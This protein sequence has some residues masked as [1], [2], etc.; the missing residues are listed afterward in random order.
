MTLLE[1]YNCNFEQ[2][3]DP[4]KR[5]RKYNSAP[6]VQAAATAESVS[7]CYTASEVQR[8][9]TARGRARISGV[10]RGQWSKTV[11]AVLNRSL[12]STRGSYGGQGQ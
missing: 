1:V 9:P 5:I 12:L 4:G 6:A 10:I 8:A 11:T 7:L 2:Y 3:A